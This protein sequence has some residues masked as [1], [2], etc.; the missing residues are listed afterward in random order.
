M[1]GTIENKKLV[2]MYLKEEVKF[3]PKKA[4]ELVSFGHVVLAVDSRTEE[5]HCG[6]SLYG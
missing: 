5:R 1:K 6:I 2:Q 3:L 4:E